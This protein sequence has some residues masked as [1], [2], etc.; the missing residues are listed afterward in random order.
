MSVIIPV[1]HE[2]FLIN[3]AIRAIKS[4]KAKRMPE[5]LVVDG[6]SEGNTVTAIV[7]PDVVKITGP[8]GRARQM[9]EGARHARG[10]I[11]L[12][13]HAD[14]RLPENGIERILS[15]MEGDGVIAGAFDLGI[16]S[17][18]FSLRLIAF[19]ASIRSRLTGIPFGDQGMF[20]RRDLFLSMGGFRDIPLMEDIDIMRRIKERAGRIVILPEQAV[21][22]ARRWEREGVFRCTIRNWFIQVLY[23]LGVSPHKLVKYYRHGN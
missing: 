21:S 7:E 23:Y 20:I 10:D 22:S 16:G 9:N 3:E 1:L 8:R 4:Q 6:D 13:L 17:K 2:S 18:Q 11:L 15:V 14:T 19:V 5:I 12:F